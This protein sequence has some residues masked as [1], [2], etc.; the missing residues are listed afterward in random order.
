MVD[1]TLF[2]HVRVLSRRHLL[3]SPVT[4]AQSNVQNYFCTV[5]WICLFSSQRP[6]K[7]RYEYRSWA[8]VLILHKKL[9]FYSLL[10]YSNIF[11]SIKMRCTIQTLCFLLLLA[12]STTRASVGGD[13]CRDCDCFVCTGD[14]V[15]GGKRIVTISSESCKSS[16]ISWQC[17]TGSTGEGDGSCSVESECKEDGK[18]KCEDVDSFELSVPSDATGVQITAHDGRFIGMGTVDQAKCGGTPQGGS[19]GRGNGVCFVEVDISEGNCGGSGGTC[20][21]LVSLSFIPL[22]NRLC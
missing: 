14:K 5:C 9:D 3:F 8:V 4:L 6:L 7:Y 10:T 16:A 15:E 22:H 17:C 2:R 1:S 12:V 11:Y 18:E 19:C 13:E 20:C 21:M